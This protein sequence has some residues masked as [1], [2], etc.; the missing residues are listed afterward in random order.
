M[1]A[2]I[3][4]EFSPDQAGAI[5]QLTGTLLQKAHY[6]QA[7]LDEHISQMFLD[8]YLD[9]MDSSHMIF[10]ARDV[11]DFKESYR[12]RL[13]G[14]T[15]RGDASP[16]F[17]IFKRYR[18]RLGERFTTVTNLLSGEFDFT[19]HEGFPTDRDD[20]PW[21]R[22]EDEVRDLWRL[23]LKYEMLTGM[24]AD[25][26]VG[27]VK[28]RLIKR[29]R[30][31]VHRM[32]QFE[33]E[34]ILQ[35]Y[36]TALANAYDPHSSYMSPTEADNFEINQI[37][38]ALTGI[39]A[40]LQSEDGYTK[41]VSLVP[42]GP[43]E[44]SGKLNPGDRIIA[45]AQGD[46][47]PVDTVEMPLKHVVKMI[48]GP[49]H[50]E[51]RLTLLPADG[52]V[53][54]EV[55]LIRDRIELKEQQ[56]HAKVIEIKPESGTEPVRYGVIDLSQFY[57]NS[58]RHVES[59]LKRL[60]EENVQGVVLD[61]RRNSGGIL[62]EAITL[63]GLFIDRGPVVQ[64]R[65]YLDR[66]TVLRDTYPQT[67]YDGPLVVLVN[68]LSASA[69]EIVAAALQDYE[70]AVIVGDE[71]THGKGTVQTVYALQE[72]ISPQFISDPGKLKFTVSK[73]YR[74]EGGTTQRHGVT[75][76]IILPSIYDYLDLGEANLENSL[77]PDK[78]A[79][80]DYDAVDQVNRYVGELRDRSAKRLAR[81]KDF[82]YI[83]QDIDLLR[84][85]RERKSISVNLEERRQEK[86]EKEA[87]EQRREEEREH[88]RK[89]NLEV[90]ELTLEM[91][92]SGDPMKHLTTE[93][94]VATV[95]NGDTR[96]RL[97]PE[98]GPGVA[99]EEPRTP[100]VQTGEA[101]EGADD[102]DTE[103]EPPVLD[104]YLEETLHILSDY[105]ELLPQ[106]GERLLAG[107]Q[108]FSE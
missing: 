86:Q 44:K 29:Y 13:A 102:E 59:L 30:Q 51:V 75:P 31:L 77:E 5:T 78:I 7:P 72:M 107:P 106:H 1:A 69:S 98:S 50:T 63:T 18:E 35:I 96:L 24:L 74:V 93:E 19:L 42:G 41:I 76:D 67:A 61:L 21:P 28:E 34:D 105:V 94:Q 14:Y 22:N 62:D 17:A 83:R 12:D 32:D 25:E 40:L 82:E 46:E 104:P 20:A 92:E 84:E 16:A 45:V 49:I 47:E 95:G 10:L 85:R 70:R 26:S 37:K 91:V 33:S 55:R 38:L 15:R 11:E 73:F 54:K 87:L 103:A 65:D 39:G 90:Y 64:V 101:A 57:E 80:V 23:R 2:G 88:R 97:H 58:A 6:K 48:R 27:E 53:K 99:L 4:V 100:G 43:A 89:P 79:M 36:L 66:R 9:A 71:S 3:G 81:N 56:A 108:W 68:R 52:S 8:N 60:E